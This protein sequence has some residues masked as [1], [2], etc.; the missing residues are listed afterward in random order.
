M[1]ENES[2]RGKN[3]EKLVI[4][5]LKN[6]FLSP[7]A[8]KS[9]KIGN[10]ILSNTIGIGTFSKVKLGIHYPTQEK[11][12]IKIL[13]KE[14]INDENDIERIS[15]EI[16]ILKVLKHENIVQLYE[17]ISSERHIYIIMEFINGKNLFHYIYT[18][19]KLN[20]NK[21]CY[22]FRQLISSLE[23]LHTLG[24]VHR[25]IK[26]E[27]IL[28]TKDYKKIKLVDF[29]LSNSYRHGNLLKTAC[30]SPCFAAPEMISGKYYNGLYSD[31]WSCGVVL[32]YMLTGKL[33]FDDSNIKVLYRKIKNG[34][35]VI[36][37][38]LS[39]ICKDFIRKILTVNPDKRIKINDLKNHPFF[40]I[41]KIPLCKGILVGIDQINIDYDLVKEI[42]LNYFFDNDKV[43]EEYIIGYILNN[44]HNNIT[45]T[46]YLLLKKKEYENKKENE[47]KNKNENK[48]IKENNKNYEGEYEN[49]QIKNIQNDKQNK[50]I[51]NNLKINNNDLNQ[52]H[53]NQ[54]Q[55]NNNDNINTNN[56]SNDY[57]ILVINNILTE[58]CINTSNILKSEKNN[59]KDKINF[60]LK[61]KK[62]ELTNLNN[63]LIT[64]KVNINNVIS[65]HLKKN[66]ISRNIKKN[67]NQALS[68]G[69]VP[70]MNK[71]TN[72]FNILN[73][74]KIGFKKDIKKYIF[75][76][77]NLSEENLKYNKLKT[78]HKQIRKRI[79]SSNLSRNIKYINQTK[80]QFKND[81][82]IKKYNLNRNINGLYIK[83][84]FDKDNSNRNKTNSRN[85]NESF[86]LTN[87]ITNSKNKLIYNFKKNSLYRNQFKPTFHSKQNSKNHSNIY[88]IE[89]SQNI[90]S[91]NNKPQKLI[92]NEWKTLNSF[93]SNRLSLNLKN[94][95]K[96]NQLVYNTNSL[97]KEKDKYINVSINKTIN[98][99]ENNNL[100]GNKNNIH[101]YLFSNLKTKK[102]EIDESKST[103]FEKRIKKNN[104]NQKKQ[105]IRTISNNSIYNYIYNEKFQY[106]KPRNSTYNSKEKNISLSIKSS[107]R[108]QK[109]LNENLF[110]NQNKRKNLSIKI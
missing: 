5:N 104:S 7:E 47:I 91:K 15:R 84:F 72:M 44:F 76:S 97:S 90:Q 63:N 24:I 4:K 9:K 106:I 53:E 68:I 87:Y 33:P 93:L 61:M 50:K 31:L 26:P 55:N 41:D 30:G 51:I 85:E 59:Q 83:K 27:N 80:T 46:Y 108:K 100:K 14:K 40:N 82:K 78:Y 22:Y 32:Y 95:S 73:S 38:F 35:Y 75:N 3:I 49:K 110:K 43:T 94:S 1:S 52:K 98:N 39:D 10:Y 21:A 74:Y 57:N 70:L 19:Q 107:S 54:S 12:A 8:I 66:N 101:N 67:K 103:N 60:N 20:E 89:N 16:H 105:K 6:N 81:N 102:N 64:T 18:F 77:P 56:S 28:L 65:E 48:N 36:P 86:N 2:D 23:Y 69:G 17:N 29:G 58:S 88:E 34:D 92:I 11:V 109:T 62:K 25:D 71:T 99:G 37:N 13:D 79:I 42:K 45:A 96:R